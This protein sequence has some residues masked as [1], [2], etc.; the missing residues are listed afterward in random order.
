MLLPEVLR[1]PTLSAEQQA[2]VEAPLDWA[3]R[4][5]AGPGAG[6]T[7]VQIARHLR[8]ID[9]GIRPES[10]LAVTLT[11]SMAVDYRRRLIASRPGLGEMFGEALCQR[12]GTIHSIGWGLLKDS[13]DPRHTVAEPAVVD[14]LVHELAACFLP[15]SMELGADQT[16][17]QF[18]KLWLRN[19]KSLAVDG[20]NAAEFYPRHMP[21]H[22]PG[23]VASAMAHILAEFNGRLRADGLITFPD[24]LAELEIRLQRDPTFLKCWQSQIHFVLIDEAQDAAAQPMRILTRLA[25][26]QNQLMLVG[27]G[28]QTLFRFLGAAPEH[29]LYDHFETHF[30]NGLTFHLTTNYR[31]AGAI[32]ATQNRLIQHNYQSG[33][34]STPDRYRKTLTPRPGAQPGVRLTFRLYPKASAEAA[35]VAAHCYELIKSRTARPQDIFVGARMRRQLAEMELTLATRGI[36]CVNLC[37]GSFWGLPHIQKLVDYLALAVDTEDDE[38]FQRVYNAATAQMRHGRQLGPQFLKACGGHYPGIETALADD[39]R[40]RTWLAGARDLQGFVAD[41]Q[42]LLAGGAPAA[43]PWPSSGTTCRRPSRRQ[44]AWGSWKKPLKIRKAKSR[45]S[46]RLQG[47]IRRRPISSPMCA[48][49]SAGRARPAAIR[50]WS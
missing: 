44:T 35:G 5:L 32:V 8:L 21:Q 9:L 3:L 38:A 45:R 42:A 6:K 24:M 49:C 48:R 26:P 22:L 36:P 2:V 31:S 41:I 25:W 39:V 14:R 20:E 30:P 7:M 16:P 27:D 23:G 13:G 4:V 15:Q 28:D 37:G 34:G 1:G 40:R 17:E 29:N 12:V 47:N 11:K 50:S 18:V 33:G 10:I 46:W 43:K 19:A